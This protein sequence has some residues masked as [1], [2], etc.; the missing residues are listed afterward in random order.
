MGESLEQ[1]YLAEL[2]KHNLQVDERLL[3]EKNAIFRE[4][5]AINTAIAR[6]GE[7]YDQD[8]SH[9]QALTE[10]RRKKQAFLEN[11]EIRIVELE[12]MYASQKLPLEVSKIELCAFFFKNFFA[13]HSSPKETLYNM[14]IL[15]FLLMFEALPAVVRLKLENGKYLAKIEHHRSMRS[16]ADNEIES[17]EHEI[18]NLDGDLNDLSYKLEKARLWRELEAASKSG[19]RDTDRLINLAK[20]LT[21]N[22]AKNAGPSKSTVKSEPKSKEAKSNDFPT[23]DYS[24]K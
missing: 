18:L 3:A 17:V 8:K 24:E 5:N 7:R 20:E 4:E 14:M 11:K 6:A 10:L 13:G 2:G 19:F 23:F 15:V 22:K 16:K 9:S 1:V 12:K 21:N